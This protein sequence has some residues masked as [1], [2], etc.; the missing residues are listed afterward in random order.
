MRG[1]T[2]QETEGPLYQS[3][4]GLYHRQG[5]LTLTRELL[6]LHPTKTIFEAEIDQKFQMKISMR[7]GTTIIPFRG[8]DKSMS[9]ILTKL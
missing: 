5:P 1:G 8:V 9:K 4:L 7:L 6:G 2:C 3:L